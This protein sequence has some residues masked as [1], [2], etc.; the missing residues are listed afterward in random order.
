MARLRLRRGVRARAFTGPK[1]AC[2]IP[3]M[4]APYFVMV[5]CEIAF[6]T[7]VNT[8]PSFHTYIVTKKRKTHSV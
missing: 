2:S 1:E 5:V 6:S 4:E 7:G 8:T 3:S